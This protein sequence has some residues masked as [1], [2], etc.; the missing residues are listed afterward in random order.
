ME[1]NDELAL[2]SEILDCLLGL[3]LFAGGLV[4]LEND[5]RPVFAF[6]P[7]LFS[8]WFYIVLFLEG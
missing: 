1:L 8:C 2:L 6:L 3:T 5:F 4:L 7:N